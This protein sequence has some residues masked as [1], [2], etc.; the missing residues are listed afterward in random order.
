MEKT[1]VLRMHLNDSCPNDAENSCP[2]SNVCV[3][4][5]WK[6]VVLVVMYVLMMRKTVVLVVMY[7]S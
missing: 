4:M 1:V 2:S 6:T 5:M 7:V 3:L